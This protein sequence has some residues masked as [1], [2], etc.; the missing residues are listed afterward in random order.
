MLRTEEGI[1]LSLLEGPPPPGLLE[2]GL[3]EI[4]G[5]RLVLT[6]T[7]SPLVDPIAA[8]LA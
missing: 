5:D 1:P 7:G 3:A 4:A 6:R 2:H 8:E